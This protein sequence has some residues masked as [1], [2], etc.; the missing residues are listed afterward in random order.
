MAIMI[1]GGGGGPVYQPQ[2]QPQS[3]TVGIND[4]LHDIAERFGVTQQAIREANPQIFS[5]RDP[6]EAKFRS[7][8][9]QAQNGGGRL[10]Q[11]DELTIPAAPMSVTEG[12]PITGEASYPSTDVKVGV[13]VQGGNGQTGS[14][15]WEPSAGKVT[16]TGGQK[17]ETPN[18]G[19]G[20]QLSARRDTA[21]AYG[22]KNNDGNTQFTVEVQTSVAASGSVDAG[23]RKGGFEAEVG[24][25]A[26]FKSS[27]QVTL[28]G[29]NRALEAAAQ[30]NPFDPTTIPVGGQVTMNS[31]AFAETSLAGSFRHIG[32][33]T[34]VQE[35]QGTSYIV[36]RTDENTVRVMMGPTESV[37]A[38][39]GVGLRAGSDLSVM[40]GRQ[41]SLA[42][43]TLRTADF[44]LSTPDGQAAYA[45]FTST[46]QVAHETAGVDNVATVERLDYSSQ[47][48][49]RA[50][51]GP[52]SVE[53]GGA[54]NTGSVVQTT[55][56]D[57]SFA[58][59]TDLGYDGNVPLQINQRF[60]AEG[61]ELLG[62]RSYQFEVA[63]DD[64]NVQLLNAVLTGSVEGSGPVEAGETATLTFSEEQIQA[65]IG[66]TEDAVD[67]FQT[68]ATDLRILVED[69]G[70]NRGTEP[71]DFAISMAR[72][73][74]SDS[75]GFVER[76]FSI[77]TAADGDIRDGYERIDAG[78]AS[79]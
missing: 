12:D 11:G 68:G 39:N 31:E 4:S 1:D 14:L 9:A 65:L 54:Q 71:M 16:L 66:Q 26:G 52:L 56:P 79:S 55:Y 38:F 27:Y 72:N 32:T 49:L 25:G 59:T 70:G 50:K 42:G 45:H 35:G 29:E 18:V 40:V 23:G 19:D 33:E 37:Q 15:T 7:M 21:V 76:L 77:S 67:T 22:Q 73:L 36:E 51:L 62:E 48:Q 13:E 47:S 78:V 34:K 58:L 24:A 64:N 10:L 17:V 5:P 43:S 69:Y 20:V 63:V 61:T 28:P 74:N 3:Y 6:G 41:D 2:N 60:D 57:G 46:G 44:D 53:L 30:V 8:E 75:Y